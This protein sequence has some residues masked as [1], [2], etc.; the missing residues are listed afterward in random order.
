MCLAKGEHIAAGVE[1][2]FRTLALQ[3]VY[4]RR[5][6]QRRRWA[7]HHGGNSLALEVVNE[8][9]GGCGQVCNGLCTL[10]RHALIEPLADGLPADTEKPRRIRLVEIP[11]GEY[12]LEGIGIALPVEMLGEGV[13]PAGTTLLSLNQPLGGRSGIEPPYPLD[14]IG[15]CLG[16]VATVCQPLPDVNLPCPTRQLAKTGN[17]GSESGARV[18]AWDQLLWHLTLTPR[19]PTFS[20]LFPYQPAQQPR[21]ARETNGRCHA[22]RRFQ[23]IGQRVDAAVHAYGARYRQ[24][25]VKPV[26][27]RKQAAETA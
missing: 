15:C 18:E 21:R 25:G 10:R 19:F 23:R 4:E 6:I 17:V 24:R 11:Y 20:G 5:I 12:A 14:Q 26:A 16:H 9:I 7:P 8:Q 27:Q 2:G 3:Q 13:E 22:Q 1:H